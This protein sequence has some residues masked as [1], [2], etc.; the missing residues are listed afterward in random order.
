MDEMKR[1]IIPEG[2]YHIVFVA[3]LTALLDKME[4]EI[5]PEGL[6]FLS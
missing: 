3:W 4:R 6:R 2:F 5:I 1:E